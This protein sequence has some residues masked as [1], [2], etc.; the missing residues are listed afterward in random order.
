MKQIWK[1]T[2]GLL[3]S[4]VLLYFLF[5]FISIDEFLEK[6]E[7]ANYFLVFL[8]TAIYLL[9]FFVNSFRWQAILQ[10][11]DFRKVSFFSLYRII[12]MSTMLNMTLPARLGELSKVYFLMAKEK[13]SFGVA[14]V[15]VV[16]ERFL[17]FLIIVFLVLIPL[18]I[19]NLLD[20]MKSFFPKMIEM[21]KEKYPSLKSVDLT[22]IIGFLEYTIYLIA[23]LFII[24]IIAILI[25]RKSYEKLVLLLQKIFFWI[26]KEHKIFEK[27][28][29]FFSQL[30][31]FTHPKQL[32]KI[33]ILSIIVWCIY[34]LSYY[35]LMQ[36][37]TIDIPYFAI[38]FILGITALGIAIPSAPAG[39]G[40]FQIAFT[41]STALVIGI[42]WEDKFTSIISCAIILHACHIISISIIGLFFFIKENITL[43][44]VTKG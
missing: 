29:H 14:F 27:I 16:S 36:A 8:G 25:F 39:I 22:S 44:E 32:I 13:T 15:T 42:H 40:P 12:A 21:L 24:G 6:L 34:S 3:I 17:D 4:G 10:A 11:N 33:L 1:I 5:T 30:K 2:I 20:Q 41:I 38:P 23:V 18:F 9:A 43:K 26:P 28:K 31:F 37:F 35:C 19:F 7:G